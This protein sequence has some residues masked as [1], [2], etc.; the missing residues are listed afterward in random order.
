MNDQPS[1][2]QIRAWARLVWA[3]QAVADAIETDLKTADFP[4]L[5][6]YDV[7]LELDRSDKGG[8]RPSEIAEVTLFTRY[9][10]TR[11]VD[12]LQKKG[13]VERVACPE[14]ARGAMV[15]ITEEGRAL[16][17]QMWPIYREAIKRHFADKLGEDGARQLG[18]LLGKLLR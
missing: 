9:N 4:P 6:W 5:S 3:S 1:D 15:R 14:D 17:A 11:L 7:L 8:L 2:S 16:R 10:V 18:E 13:L 12:R